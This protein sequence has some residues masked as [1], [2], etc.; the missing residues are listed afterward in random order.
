MRVR[1]LVG[2]FLLAL[3]CARAPSPAP[4][5]DWVSPIGR[6]H[7]LAGRVFD[8][9]TRSESSEPELLAQARAARFVLLGESHENADHHRLQAQ[10]IRALGADGAGPAVAFEML[11]RDQQAALDEALAGPAPTPD[12]V[13]AATGWDQSGWP[14]FAL[15]TPVFEAALAAR[16]PLVAADLPREEQALVASNDPLPA[17]LR[18]RLGLDEPLPQNVQLALERDLLAAHCDRLPASELPRMVRVQRARDAA[19]AQAL[20]D[21]PGADGAEEEDA[22]AAGEARGA[23]RAVL[24]AGAEHVRL[25][26]GV[27]RAL[28]SLAPGA[29]RVA[30]AFL[31]VDP[32]EEDLFEDLATRY[33]DAPP[34]DYVWYTPKA[35]DEDYC[36]RIRRKE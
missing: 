14:D 26:R 33:G 27:P 30:V 31:E 9:R 28:E 20:L 29:D 32:D 1:S 36:E 7:P 18:A 13:R 12:A 22:P 8:L 24:I 11:R 35:S 23:G 17:L 2:L 6:D 19:L 34:F 4:R 16:L 5:A 25:D 3:A 15:Y 10:V 21:A